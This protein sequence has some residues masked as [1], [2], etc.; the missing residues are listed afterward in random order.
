MKLVG[1]LGD[2]VILFAGDIDCGIVELAGTA[3][4][5]VL[6]TPC[7]A[8]MFRLGMTGGPTC[9]VHNVLRT[10]PD[11]TFCR[12]HATVEGWTV[13]EPF[14]N[15]TT[16]PSRTALRWHENSFKQTL[17]SRMIQ[18]QAR[19]SCNKVNWEEFGQAVD[20]SCEAYKRLA[21][22]QDPR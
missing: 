19:T 15:V 6:R 16:R 22:P 10:T 1:I 18:R 11:V 4:F 3:F 14:G 21:V 2:Q 8:M 9:P 17:G 20:D 13:Q 5:R 12:G 7:D